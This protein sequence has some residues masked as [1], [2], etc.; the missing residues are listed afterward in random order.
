MTAMQ[1]MVVAGRQGSGSDATRRHK[2]GPGRS[3]WTLK[4]KLWATLGLMW[5]VM[6]GIVVGMAWQGRGTMIEDRRQ[7]LFNTVG[8]V[9]TLLDGYAEGVDAG[10]FNTDEAQRR[11]AAALDAMR[12]GRDRSN[13]LFVFDKNAD[14]VYHPRREPGSDMSD[15]RDPN[16]VA[17]YGE[18]ARIAGQ[19]GGYLAYHSMRGSASDKTRYPKLSYVERFAPW[20]W[21][22]A[23]GVYVDDIQRV[24]FGKLWRYAVILLIAGGALTAVFLLLIRNV[25]NSLGG[26]PS[27]AA[28]VVGRVADGD[29]THVTPLRDGDQSSLMAAIERMRR[30]LAST[31]ARLRHASESI[32]TGAR[33]IAAGNNDLSSRTEQQAA[34]L[35]ETA[36]SMEQLTSTVSQNADNAAQANRLA[37]QTTESVVK[38]QEVIARV[39]STMGDIRE[40]SGQIAD[41]I[42]LIDGIAFQTNLLAL[43]A[44]V[45]A[46]R[47]GEQGRGFAV[48]AGE[49]RNLAS[50]SAQAASDIKTLIERSVGQVTSGAD[51][52]N[53]ADGAMNEIRE[54]AQRVSDLMGEISAASN[55]QSSGIEQVNQAVAQMDQVTQQNAALVQQAASAAESLEDQASQLHQTVSRFRVNPSA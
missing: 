22:V 54:S 23:A 51:L 42:S 14:I 5:L 2:S 26:E 6:I 45:E 34:S 15:Y 4:R 19:G 13:Y 31:I 49:V 41:I 28:G 10:E 50:R 21:N 1:G 43:N 29:L 11:A 7:S 38:G 44:S 36:A 33:E 35:A 52:V 48:V 16:G 3:G 32:D 39:V 25:Y 8:M 18:L 53:Q 12:F 37:S 30:E 40:S 20:G 55:E 47:A 24:F 17:V 46:A 27:V 9:T